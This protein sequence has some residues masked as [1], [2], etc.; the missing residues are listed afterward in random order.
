MLKWKKYPEQKP[1]KDT[2]DCILWLKDGTLFSGAF[3]TPI[4]SEHDHS[5]WK[6]T[7]YYITLED[8]RKLEKEEEV[9]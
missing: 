8:L 3:W 9:E 5:I 2:S 7:D 1:T 6:K 4:D